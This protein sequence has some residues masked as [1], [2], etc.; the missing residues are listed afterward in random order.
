MSVP[1]AIDKNKVKYKLVKNN[2]FFLLSS[3]SPIY[4]TKQWFFLLYVLSVQR[5][6][7]YYVLLNA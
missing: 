7:L 5:N 6:V 1:E 2:Y 4:Y 3:R